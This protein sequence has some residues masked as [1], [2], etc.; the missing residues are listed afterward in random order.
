MDKYFLKLYLVDNLDKLE[1]LLT[2]IGLVHIRKCRNEYYSCGFSGSKRRD[3]IQV[4]LNSKLTVKVWS[5]NDKIE[6]IYGLVKYQMSCG[7]TDAINIV[8]DVC[9]IKR[10]GNIKK[11]DIFMRKPKEIKKEYKRHEPRILNEKCL[12]E[13]IEGECKIFSDDGISKETQRYYS[14][15]FDSL[16]NRVVFPVRDYE[17]NLITFKGRTLEKDYIQKGI[18]KYLYYHRFD[19][20]YYLFGYYE[21]YFEIKE[22]EY[23]IVGE[24]E[25]MP[26][27]LHSYEIRNCIATSKK[28]IS[29]E[30]A[31]EL[32][33]LNKKIVLAYDNDVTEEEIKEECK[34]LKGDVYYIKDSWGMLDKKDSPIDKGIDVWN[35]LYKH[36]IKFKE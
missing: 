8:A 5:K 27:Q 30:Q 23:L 24:S 11:I 21:N 25:K 36:K 4:F 2:R 6:D 17:G 14:I 33:K 20:R 19:G 7:F 34:K 12:D 31:I 18:P 13:F 35:F 1:E 32:N 16:N 3:S 15:K 9:A 22:N 28:R 29:V 26:M 10:C